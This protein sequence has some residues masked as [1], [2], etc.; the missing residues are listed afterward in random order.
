MMLK[1]AIEKPSNPHTRSNPCPS[2]FLDQT[3]RRQSNNNKEI[4]IKSQSN[5]LGPPLS[6]ISEE[7][8]AQTRN[9]KLNAEPY[10]PGLVCAPKCNP[11]RAARSLQSK[12]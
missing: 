3:I 11:Q 6:N 10:L 9:P 1:N 7:T 8:A 2:W 12:E 5:Q 4:K